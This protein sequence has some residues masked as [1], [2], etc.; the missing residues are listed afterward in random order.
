MDKEKDRFVTALTREYRQSLERFLS[1]KL[2]DPADAA[3]VAQEAL[4]RLYRLQRPQELD[5]PRAFLFQVASNLAVDQLRRRALHQRFLNKEKN[6]AFMGD[7]LDPNAAGA[8]PDQVLEAQQKL[9]QIYHAIETLPVNCRQAFLMHRNGNMSYTEI[10]REMG[11]SVSS[12]EKYI[13]KALK[14]CRLALARYYDTTAR[15]KEK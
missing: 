8:A 15:E 10:A 13:L 1:S 5:N 3:D 7:S 14:H 2:E 4:L 12:V 9:Q 6:Q 11:V